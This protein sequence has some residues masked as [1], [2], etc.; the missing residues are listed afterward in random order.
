M[1]YRL[2]LIDEFVVCVDYPL[3]QFDNQLFGDF[4]QPLLSNEAVSI[5]H[6]LHGLVNLGF[7]ESSKTPHKN[8]LNLLKIDN[9]ESFQSFREE[10]EAIGLL[11]TFVKVEKETNLYIYI[12][13]KIPTPW[14]FFKDHIRSTML[15]NAI[16]KE[17]FLE[18]GGKYLV[19]KYDLPKFERVTKSLDEVYFVPNPNDHGLTSWWVNPRSAVNIEKYH[20]DYEYYNVLLSARN[21]VDQN[22][23]N[24][25]KLYNEVNRLAWMFGLSTDDLVDATIL[26]IVNNELDIKELRTNCRKIYTTKNQ[27]DFNQKFVKIENDNTDS[28]LVNTL[29]SITPAQLVENKYHTKLTGSEIELFDRLLIDTNISVGVLNALI[30]Y[31]M[32]T[33]NGEIPSYNY[34]LKIVNTWIR[35][36]IKTTEQALDLISN[37]EQKPKTTTKVQKKTPTWFNDYINELESKDL[38]E[39]QT[40]EESLKELEQF[41]NNKKGK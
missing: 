7:Y 1:D 26:S 14:E 21:V 18:L 2:S 28:V 10:L 31:V 22:L 37:G 16:G 19:H 3:S 9:I 8:L 41:F 13:K 35:K 17:N 32:D 25:A 4:F 15:E 30:I 6:K 27:T 34:F 38:N 5:F 33:K 11:D 39:K 36:G 12:L 40:S 23:L 20:F 29:N 24:S